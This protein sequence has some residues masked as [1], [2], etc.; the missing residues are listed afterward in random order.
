MQGFFEAQHVAVFGVSTKESNLGARIVNNLLQFKFSGRIT[1]I[2]RGGGAIAGHRIW[3]NLAESGA[4]GVDLAVVL[5]PARTIPDIMEACGKLGIR[6]MVIESGGFAEL[7]EEGLRLQ[8]QLLGIA[9]KYDIRFVGPNGLGVTDNHTGLAVPFS[10][11][12]QPRRG[13]VSIITQSGGVGLLYANHFLEE[14]IGMSKF[15]S[16]GNKI[17]V[18][19][20]DLLQFLRTD[21]RTSMILAYLES[22]P[23]GRELFEVLRACQKPVVIHK[24]NISDSSRDIASS[25]T[26]A[27]VNDDAVVDAALKQ[28]GVLRTASLRDTI[29]KV[30]AMHLPPMKGDRV[31][32]VSRS[33][34]HAIIAADECGK[35]GLVFPK[36]PAEFLKRVEKHVRPGVIRMG[37]PLDVGDLYDMEAYLTI[38]EEVMALPNNDAVLFLFVMISRDRPHVA[39]DLVDKAKELTE[40]HQKPLALVLYTWPEILTSMH[41]YSAFPVFETTQEAVAALA[42]GRDWAR[43]HKSAPKRTPKVR[44][45]AQGVKLV[46]QAEPGRYLRQ[47]DAFALLESYGL[48]HP[49]VRLV[50]SQAE[51]ARAFDEIGGGCVAMKIES[52][53]V[54][55]KS[56]VGGVILNVRSAREARVAF[57]ELQEKLAE[58]KPGARFSGALLMPM[59]RRGVELIAG[60]KVD[61]SFGP[62]VMLGW[63]GT[64]AEAMERVSLRLAPITR[65]E[66]MQMIA[67]LPGQKLLDGFRERPPVSRA[68][69]ATAL[70]KLSHL[71]HT[72]GLSEVDVNPIAAYP[73]GVMALDARVLTLA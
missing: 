27:L 58:H 60:V 3:N 55:H 51:A 72:P 8:Q 13:D 2:G 24:S 45:H 49:P 7:D 46:Q 69:L 23:K 42:A 40:K 32:V 48:K 73:D 9:A 44:L 43:F 61:P 35:H 50:A 67:E 21:G 18:D 37:N 6:R 59:A 31:I 47:D 25:H 54:V 41:A 5:T 29:I 22:L 52:P 64:A 26:A 20:I 16:M 14:G 19:E 36:L 70:V 11:M 53:D 66:A 1:L 57:L 34:G 12:P 15:V 4:E 10:T 30:K 33:G 56:D 28:T 71:A 65:H 17:N 62:V 39:R 38:M 63:G 68:A